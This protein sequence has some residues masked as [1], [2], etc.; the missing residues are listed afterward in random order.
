MSKWF[1]RPFL[2]YGV[3]ATPRRFVPGVVASVYGTA[4]QPA[5]PGGGM[6]FAAR[7]FLIV[8]EGGLEQRE[9]VVSAAFVVLA[10]I[11]GLVA[12]YVHEAR[13][14][15]SWLRPTKLCQLTCG[16]PW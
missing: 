13:R 4:L 3:N 16:T 15:V 9:H 8:F 1:G 2:R 11:I 10:L 7:G 5:P 6:F 14:H 12:Y